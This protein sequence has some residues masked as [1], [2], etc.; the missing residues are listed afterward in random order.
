[1]TDQAP[2]VKGQPKPLMIETENG[3]TFQES[4]VTNADSDKP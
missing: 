2:G 4:K 3:F 1:M